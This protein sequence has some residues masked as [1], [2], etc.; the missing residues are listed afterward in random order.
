M[1]LTLTCLCRGS[2]NNRVQAFLEKIVQE[3]ESFNPSSD[4]RL[5]Y[6]IFIKL[7]TAVSGGSELDTHEVTGYG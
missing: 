3:F 6:G 2:N 1:S 4:S 7:A 5:S